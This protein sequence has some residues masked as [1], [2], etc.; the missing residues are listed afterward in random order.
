MATVM[1]H[2]TVLRSLTN[3]TKFGAVHLKAQYYMMTGYL[4]PVGVQAPSIGAA[5]AR[6][7]GRATRTCR[8]TF[9]SAATSTPATPKSSSSATTSGRAFTA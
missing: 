8:R 4:F 3:A 9:T 6:T 1:H 2:G 7:L 5:I